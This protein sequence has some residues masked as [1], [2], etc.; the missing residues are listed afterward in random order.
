MRSLLG[1]GSCSGCIDYSSMQ[2]HRSHAASLGP[3]SHFK[4]LCELYCTAESVFLPCSPLILL[5]EYDKVFFPFRIRYEVSYSFRII[6]QDR[7]SNRLQ[8][9]R[10][11]L[12]S[13]LRDLDKSHEN[14]QCSKRLLRL[15]VGSR[16]KRLDKIK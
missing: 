10:I 9:P 7:L 5:D 2:Y 8:N 6:L 15:I 13:L 16:C 11:C 3:A 12:C 14:I 4:C 1:S